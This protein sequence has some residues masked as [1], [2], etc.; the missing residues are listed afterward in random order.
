MGTSEER[1]ARG[2][3]RIKEQIDD[4]FSADCVDS[5]TCLKEK[6]CDS[7][8]PVGFI[9][10]SHI[11]SLIYLLLDCDNVVT[12]VKC[13]VKFR[14]NMSVTLTSNNYIIPKEVYN[15]LLTDGM[16][17]NVGQAVNLL[18]FAKALTSDNAP[19]NANIYLGRAISNL[20]TY[21]ENDDSPDK[22]KI[23]FLMEQLK[24]LQMS[25]QHRTYSPSLLVTASNWNAI[26]PRC[27]RQILRTDALTL[28]SI[29]TLYRISNVLYLL[30]QK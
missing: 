27:Y 3:A 28:P 5:I 21:L 29:S 6:L 14:E 16:I 26:S 17:T 19:L 10:V 20:S 7:T 22:N 8:L 23:S 18:A 11:D 4:F 9:E 30:V 13:S 2:N 12:N 15:H 1:L 24:L 25:K